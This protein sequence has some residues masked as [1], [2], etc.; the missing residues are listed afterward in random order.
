MTYWELAVSNTTMPQRVFGAVL[1]TLLVVLIDL[2]S[3]SV[4]VLLVLRLLFGEQ[5]WIV[6]LF[7]SLQPIAL[8]PAPFLLIIALPLRK[9]RL[10]AQ[11]LPT[12][13]VLVMA[14]GA[15]FVPRSQAIPPEADTVTVMT[16]N[17]LADI[18]PSADI[19]DVIRDTTPDIIA[20][21]EYSANA[22]A[23]VS[24]ELASTYPHQSA[25]SDATVSQGI[26]SRYPIVSE[27]F[28]TVGGRPGYQRI[29]VNR[30]GERLVVYNIHTPPPRLIPFDARGRRSGI[31]DLLARLVSER[32]PTVVLG[33]FNMTDQ[34]TDYRRLAA[35]YPDAYR[36]VGYGFGNT[37]PNFGQIDTTQ[38]DV[39]APLPWIPPL[40]RIDYAFHNEGLRALSAEVWPQTG[41]SDH[42]PLLVTFEVVG[43]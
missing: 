38:R 13:A 6:G 25:R 2:Y 11:L 26:L 12:V 32:N 40:L 20:L 9:I 31:D 24:E 37:F 23:V 42:H 8:L 1:I 4:I 10:I 34:S 17:V 3:I 43:E 35:R 22:A 15:L 41:G 39:L 30:N 28:W 16:Y 33:D 5:W 21:Q 29:T 18:S 36:E 19:I 27:R 7:N 14:Y